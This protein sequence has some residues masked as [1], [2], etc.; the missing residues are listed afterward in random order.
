MS[1]EPQPHRSRSGPGVGALDRRVANIL[2]VGFVTALSLMLA[3]VVLSVLRDQP[4]GDSVVELGDLPGE[5]RRFNPQGIVDLGILA[6]LAT[7]LTYVLVAMGTYIRQRDW[8]FAAICC[9]L[10]AILTC[11][12]VLAL[13]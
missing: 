11:S 7:P 9:A 13:L 10:V 3:G 1:A 12:V 8:V 4:I 6:L 5:L 2:R